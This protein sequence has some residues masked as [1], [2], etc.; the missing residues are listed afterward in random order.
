MDAIEIAKTRAK[1]PADE[2]VEIVV[3]PARR[4]I[5]EAIR[6]QLGA[7]SG[8]NMWSLLMNSSERRALA[9]LSAPARLFRR[10]EPLALMPW[11][12]AR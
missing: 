11:G 3:Y 10:G 2:E 7:A 5:Y 8:F 12:F 4:S 9:A 6:E 1:I